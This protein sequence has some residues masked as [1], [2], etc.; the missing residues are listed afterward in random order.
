MTYN[1]KLLSILAL[2]T[3]LFAAQ[4]CSYSFTGASVPAHLKTIYILNAKD[5][6]GSGIAYLGQHFTEQLI[7]NF[8]DDNNLQYIQNPKADAKMDCT[9][10]SLS[11]KPVAV[12]NFSTTA[13]AGQVPENLREISISIKV[14][15]R[16]QIKRKTLINK[17]F[18]NKATFNTSDYEANR[19]A[20]IK[21]VLEKL[22]EDILLGAVSNW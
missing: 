4:A 20:A 12:S 6:T 17:T 5:K 8:V 11:D 7:D 1:K 3:V 19:E 14:I 21:Q 9:I 18:S 13:N 15:Y 16:D 22:A 10:S 2:I